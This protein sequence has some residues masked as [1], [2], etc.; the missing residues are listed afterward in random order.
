[1]KLFYLEHC[2]HCIRA[3]KWIQELYE[4]N[5]AYQEIPIEMIDEAKE[6]ELADSYDYYYVPCLFDGETKLH[7]GVMSK[8]I[9]RQ[10]FDTYLRRGKE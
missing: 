1:M 10:I 9:I 6:V 5:P 7:E 3:R 8:E 2:P 4:E